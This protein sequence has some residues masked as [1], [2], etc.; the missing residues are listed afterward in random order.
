MVQSD[1]GSKRFVGLNKTDEFRD[2]LSNFI[3]IAPHPIS[4]GNTVL[5]S[6]RYSEGQN[7]MKRKYLLISLI[8]L[9]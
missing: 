1:V 4:T 5:M 7:Q 8:C 6:R 3:F 2:R 9:L